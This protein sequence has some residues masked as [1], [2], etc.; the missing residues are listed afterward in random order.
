MYF[1]KFLKLQ[2]PFN[3]FHAFY[4]YD[5]ISY[6]FQPWGYFNRNQLKFYIL[7]AKA[8]K[9]RKT[10]IVVSADSEWYGS[11]PAHP[12]KPHLFDL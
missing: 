3:N 1:N 7:Y 9:L 11:M 4:L 2:H 10:C 6:T 5:A 8:H 12:H